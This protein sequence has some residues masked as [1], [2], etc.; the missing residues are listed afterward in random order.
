MTVLITFIGCVLTIVA[1]LC[2]N[3][4]VDPTDTIL[5]LLIILGIPIFMGVFLLFILLKSYSRLT[6][7]AIH[8]VTRYSVTFLMILSIVLPIPKTALLNDFVF[9]LIVI[10]YVWCWLSWRFYFEI[11][12]KRELRSL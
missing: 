1:L 6:E 10:M 5:Q 9:M 7:F 3:S 2:R 4:E 11:K 8:P 12:R